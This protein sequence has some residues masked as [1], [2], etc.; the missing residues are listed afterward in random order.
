[1]K[2]SLFSITAILASFVAAN[3]ILAPR[4]PS[5]SFKLL[6]D[7]GA[8]TPYRVLKIIPV[9]D[10]NSPLY[11]QFG[12]YGRYSEDIA[13]YFT[14]DY[15]KP[16]PVFDSRLNDYEMYVPRSA[17]PRDYPANIPS[18]CCKRSWVRKV[19]PL[20]TDLC[21]STESTL[22]SLDSSLPVDS[23]PWGT[24]TPA[25]RAPMAPRTQMTLTACGG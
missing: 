18:G 20:I 25:L 10:P 4:D 19:T 1:M 17:L 2:L 5:R 21:F 6:G 11:Y 15:F 22:R 23:T 9:N 16:G 7:V 3:P 14:G 13:L 24:S 8:S 12:W